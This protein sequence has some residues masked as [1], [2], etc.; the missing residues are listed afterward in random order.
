MNRKEK[1]E[2]I[3]KLQTT[4][5]KAESLVIAHQEGLTVAESSD[6]RVKMREAG[7]TYKV[8]KNRIVKLALKGTKFENLSN[9]FA[10]P[11]SIGTSDDPVSAAK[12]LVSFAK[13][14]EK[15]KIVGGGLDGKVL[16][17]ENVES[18]AKL[19]SLDELRSQIIGLV[20]SPATKLAQ[21]SKASA[22]KLVMVI[23]LKSKQ[24]IN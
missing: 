2:L 21:L 5:N 15:L 14:N 8:T 17:K 4:F 20:N 24:T 22:Q 18:L 7:A 9:F 12:V 3:D 13:E 11:T 6:L 1:A 23:N 10:G 19:P 16:Q